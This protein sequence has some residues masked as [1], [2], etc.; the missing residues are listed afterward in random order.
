MNQG[1][2]DLE[3]WPNYLSLVSIGD[4]WCFDV[5][6]EETHSAPILWGMCQAPTVGQALPLLLYSIFCTKLKKNVL[7]THHC[8]GM[9]ADTAIYCANVMASIYLNS[10]DVK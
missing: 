5:K 8:Q 3:F 1:P 4:C 9:N 10:V 7:R 2:E 6:L